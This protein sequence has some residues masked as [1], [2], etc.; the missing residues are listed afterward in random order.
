MHARR[1]RCAGHRRFVPLALS[2]LLLL[3]G[4]SSRATP[5]PDVVRP[6][7]TMVVVAGE[8]PHTRFFPGKVE[9]SKR[10]ELAFQVPG[11]LVKV[12][13][14][15]GQKVK[16][17]EVIAQLRQDEFKA[18]LKT[19]QGQL[20]QAQA[21]LKALQA[22]ERPEQR[23]RLEAQLRAAETKLA[24]ARIEVNA[25][26]RLFR[27]RAI[28]R[29]ELDRDE[30]TFRV[31]REDVEAARQML[32]KGTTAREEDIEAKKAE[33]RGLEGRV[34]EAK[35]Q[36][37]DTTL[38][39]PYDGVIAKRFVDKKQPIQAKSPVV[40]FQDVD[41]ID[42]AVDVPEAVMAADIRLAD[43]LKLVAEFTGAPG[44][45]FPVR[46]REVAQAADPT[47]Q[48]FRV[49]VAMKAPADVTLRPGMT[50]KVTVTYRRASILGNAILVP[51]SAV[52]KDGSG[53][54]VA[55]VVGPEQTVSRRPLRLGEAT[56]GRSR[57]S[58]GWSPASA[59]PW[60]G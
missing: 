30:K 33:V 50:A 14:E 2:L 37:D 42:V 55:W 26:R 1:C 49:R 34:V 45:Q 22:G 10:V 7:K 16:A 40:R 44:Q 29:T 57:S 21:G 20:D 19:L 43:I 39:A 23:L 25:S 8:A 36:L 60:R 5:P 48:T 38:R 46:I 9:A 11:V 24:N 32:E 47:T 56:G 52:A 27:S 18:R 17:G 54:Q 35:I 4:C 13:V 31:A 6:V 58:T 51:V 15:E 41:E 3:A 53:E 12:P 28:S 59:S